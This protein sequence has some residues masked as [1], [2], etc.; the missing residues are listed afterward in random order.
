[1]LGEIILALFGLCLYVGT[2]ICVVYL[3]FEETETKKSIDTLKKSAVKN[4]ENISNLQTEVQESNILLNDRIDKAKQL[5]SDLLE[6]ESIERKAVSSNLDDEKKFREKAVQ[7]ILSRLTLQ[8]K[9]ILAQDEKFRTLLSDFKVQQEDRD[10]AIISSFTTQMRN[11]VGILGADIQTTKD[12]LLGMHDTFNTYSS[13][14]NSAIKT[15]GSD[16]NSTKD[17]ISQLQTSF[18]GINT[19]LSQANNAFSDFTSN[20]N[21]RFNQ[22]Q[23]QVSTL[24]SDIRFTSDEMVQM[25]ST[26]Q[27][28]QSQTNNVVTNLASWTKSSDDR[29]G[30]INSNIQTLNNDVQTL[31]QKINS[32]QSV[33]SVSGLFAVTNQLPRKGDLIGWS[34]SITLSGL[35]GNNTTIMDD[36]AKKLVNANTK[37]TALTKMSLQIIPQIWVTGRSG[38]DQIKYTFNIFDS[39]NLLISSIQKQDKS[40]IIV[41]LLPGQSWGLVMNEDTVGAIYGGSELQVTTTSEL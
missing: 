40:V 4:E 34:P 31:K 41:D 36:F 1:M 7:D 3:F 26:L 9:T 10:T 15:L 33:P 14:T 30:T 17:E 35:S 38:D 32:L 11:Q 8:D 24:G 13:V 20:S 16:I 23:T 25:N 22:L 6:K 39:N 19:S 28:V 12:D 21:N 2:I 18:S 27:T 37:Y 5:L 29:I